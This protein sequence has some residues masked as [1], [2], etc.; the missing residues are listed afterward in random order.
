M[1]G[2]ALSSFHFKDWPLYHNSGV[3]D[4]TYAGIAVGCV[5]M[6]GLM[7]GLTLGLMSL[8]LVSCLAACSASCLEH[9][10]RAMASTA[11]ASNCAELCGR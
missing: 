7:S 6:A 2:F 10:I 1:M 3:L 8:N 11:L 5:V 4:L 9:D